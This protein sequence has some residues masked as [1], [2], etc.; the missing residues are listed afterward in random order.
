MTEGRALEFEWAEGTDRVAALVEW[1]IP[2]RRPARELVSILQWAVASI[3]RQYTGT[4]DSGKLV[5]SVG[6]LGYE[7]GQSGHF[8]LA[9]L[10]PPSSL[11]SA[12]LC[13]QG[14]LAESFPSS[15]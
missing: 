10:L 3:R 4:C 7:A 2:I 13:P 14:N 5:C 11:L 6:W 15:P 12:N 1:Q 8:V 9:S